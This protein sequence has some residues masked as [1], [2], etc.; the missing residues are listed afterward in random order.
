MNKTRVYIE[1]II[2]VVLWGGSFIATKIALK[3]LHPLTLVWLRFG[4][5][6]VFLG[7][8]AGIRRQL[9][10][11]RMVDIPYLALLGLIGIT[12]HQ[13]L[14]S[15]GLVTS[16]ASTSAWIV[17]SIPVFTAIIGWLVLHE[18]LSGVQ[19]LGILLAAGGVLLVVSGGN[20]A[21]VFQGSLGK[22][23]DLLLL[24]SAP[25]WALF[26]VL[27]RRMLKSHPAAWTMF[28]VMVFG[29]IFTSILVILGPGLSRVA[30]GSSSSWA[31]VI[32]LG[33]LCSG[34]AYVFYYDALEVLPAS[35]AGVFVYLEP[36]V[37]M[38]VS[39]LLLGEVIG[40]ASVVGGAVILFGVWL[41]QR[42]R[43]SEK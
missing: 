38:V 39:A 41:V 22:P 36:L 42:K 6:V 24:V 1:L 3:D 43:R 20:F 34:L 16:Q 29:W 19:I 4:M 32:F 5:G 13:W 31:T 11:P 28:F 23:G 30:I 27:S 7:A 15:T 12:F 35:E 33:V 40:I 18:R 10:R 37:T 2:A 9:S 17:A 14:Q 21:S 26:S 25:N 8:A